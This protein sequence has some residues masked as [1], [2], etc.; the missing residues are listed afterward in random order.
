MNVGEDRKEERHYLR[1]YGKIH[2]LLGVLIESAS[3]KLFPGSIVHEFR[4]NQTK[5]MVKD[6]F[7]VIC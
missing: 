6:H 2:R 3:D 7:V 4:V 5:I 1:N